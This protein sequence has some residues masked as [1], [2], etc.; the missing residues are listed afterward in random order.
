MIQCSAITPSRAGYGGAI[1]LYGGDTE[2]YTSIFKPNL[3][4]C[5][6]AGVKVLVLV[7]HILSMAK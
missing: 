5:D 4:L 1:T 3:A 6:P 7:P 2:I